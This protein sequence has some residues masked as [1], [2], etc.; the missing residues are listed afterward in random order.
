MDLAVG[1][2]LFTLP[3]RLAKW[4][5]PTATEP[6]HTLF[7]ISNLEQSSVVRHFTRYTPRLY[8]RH[9]PANE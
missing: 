8:L 3:N 1:L 6:E 5:I 4:P 2:R 9:I 7:F